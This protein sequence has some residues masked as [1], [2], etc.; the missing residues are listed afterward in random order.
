MP[1]T[2]YNWW[3]G[4]TMPKSTYSRLRRKFGFHSIRKVGLVSYGYS[5][6]KRDKDLYLV[7]IATFKPNTSRYF[8]KVGLYLNELYAY[9]KHVTATRYF[10]FSQ[11]TIEDSLIKLLEEFRAPKKWEI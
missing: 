5:L 1:R 9:N 10:P 4:W 2:R 3:G 11:N 7:L 6:K 8:S